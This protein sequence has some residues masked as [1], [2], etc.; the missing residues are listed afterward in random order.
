M[1]KNTI[2]DDT[3]KEKTGK[4]WEEWYDLLDSHNCQKMNHKEI[5]A[6][7]RDIDSSV[8]EWWQQE[9]TVYYERSRGLRKVYE[10]PT[11]FEI[12]ISRTINKPI[13]ELYS[14]FNAETKRKEWLP[15]DDF[16]IRKATEF[17]SLRVTWDQDKSSLN[18][19]FYKKNDE[20]SQVVI[21]HVKLKS[22]TEAKRSALFWSDMLD[23]L[24][25]I[26]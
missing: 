15:F 25:E 7:I 23:K 24:K 14:Y 5:V 2:T 16:T 8:S 12:S 4:S 18:I 1:E 13:E 9:I 3:A 20:K 10:K 11:G 17:K 6:I 19:N 26:I 22:D 21:Q